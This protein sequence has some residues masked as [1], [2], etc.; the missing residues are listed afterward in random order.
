MKTLLLTRTTEKEANDAELMK[1]IKMNNFYGV[2]FFFSVIIVLSWIVDNGQRLLT[3]N[4]S[5]S[6]YLLLL[7]VLKFCSSFIVTLWFS[8]IEHSCLRIAIRPVYAFDPCLA[9]SGRIF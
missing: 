6:F 3:L 2:F 1:Q 4:F 5:L 7:L 8:L 9:F